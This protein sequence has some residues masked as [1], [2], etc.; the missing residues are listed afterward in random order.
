MR[1]KRNACVVVIHNIHGETCVTDRTNC[2]YFVNIF[3][4]ISRKPLAVR[5]G[6]SIPFDELKGNKN[7]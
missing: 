6:A 7:A 1:M 4:Y 3:P 5:N 2:Y